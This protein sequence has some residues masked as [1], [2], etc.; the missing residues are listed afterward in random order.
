MADLFP[1]LVMRTVNN[2][3]IL[4]D[5][6]LGD[7]Q[8]THHVDQP[9]QPLRADPHGR[10]G[11]LFARCDLLLRAQGFCHIGKRSRL[12]SDQGDPYGFI[13]LLSGDG[14]HFFPVR[15]MCCYQDVPD[16]HRL[17]RGF[18]QGFR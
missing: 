5:H 15:L 9:V 12:R 4:G 11:A 8:F 7:H 2:R 17:G 16:P 6:R 18:E 1:E 13:P 14:V 10:L 3:H